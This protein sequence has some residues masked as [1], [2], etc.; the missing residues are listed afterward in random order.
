MTSAAT[1]P[2]TPPLSMGILA[3]TA[4]SFRRYPTMWFGGVVLGTMG[5]AAIFAPLIAPY[6]P[7]ALSVAN[8][9]SGPT[10]D[11]WFG[12]DSVGRDTFSRIIY[13]ARVSLAVGLLVSIMASIVGILIGLLCGA[14]K[15]ID[16]IVMRFVD[17]MMSIPPI[18]LAI[19]LVA[20]WGTNVQNV[21]IALTI[22]DAPRVARLMRSVV[23][24]A[25]EEPYVDAAVTSGTRSAKILFRHILPNTFAPILV[26]ATY[27]FASA[28]VA[29]ASLSFIGAGVPTNIPAWGSMMSEARVLWQIHPQTVFIPAAFLSL[30]VLS[31]N[32]I[33]DGLRDA[34]DP[35]L[36]KRL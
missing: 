17:G 13:G 33:G 35:R 32:M 4:R 25:R 2:S 31:V 12:T 8:R 11:F 10:A 16:L 7:N 18:L 1:V 27:I 34:L 20:L 23:L 28:M 29:E 14:H 26:Q 30:A 22:A 15:I 36:V 3:T 9:L 5:L 19:A 21:I 24:S 6:D